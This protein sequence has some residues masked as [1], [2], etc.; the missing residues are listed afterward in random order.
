MEHHIQFVS[1]L[2][3]YYYNL[4]T[5]IYLLGKYQTTEERFL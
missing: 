1:Y 5:D 2:M 4:H 3:L